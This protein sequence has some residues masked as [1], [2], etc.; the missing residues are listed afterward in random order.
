M[1]SSINQSVSQSVSQPNEQ[2][3]TGSTHVYPSGQVHTVLSRH[4]SEVLVL[5]VSVPVTACVDVR[6]H[7]ARSKPCQCYV[8]SNACAPLPFV[9][10]LPLAVKAGVT[11]YGPHF[12]AVIVWQYD[13]QAGPQSMT[14]LVE[15][16]EQHSAI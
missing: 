2:L 11:Q 15:Q 8:L 1:N 14:K 7:T 13:S 16:N 12:A 10:G 9:P 4:L 5:T 6:Q 3:I